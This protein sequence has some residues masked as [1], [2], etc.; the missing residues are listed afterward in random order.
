MSNILSGAYDM[1]VHT[2]PDVSPRK[3]TDL[4]MAI[5]WESAGMKGGV[6]KC[7]FSD[8]TGRAEILSALYPK[9]KI[10]G[11]LVLNRQAGG[12]NPD[13]AERMAQAGG[14]YLWFPTMDSK[15]YQMH[16]VKNNSQK[17]L[18]QYISILDENGKLLPKVYDVI[19]VAAKYDLIVVT[20][21]IGGKEGLPLVLEAARRGVKRIVLTHAENPA[22]FFSTD[23]QKRCVAAGA[24][25]EHSF[26][27]IYHNRVSWE[28][29]MDQIRIVG[30][31]NT[32]LV[33]DF[34]QINSPGSAEG[35]KMFAEGLIERGFT[36]NDIDK[37]IR[38]NQER[39]FF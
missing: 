35:L 12:I 15:S 1:H 4:E 30:T 20:G 28:S 23:D 37:M 10:Y 18:S 39:L 2:S 36:E 29:V 8:T 25:V 14:K 38:K 27:T 9:L 34:G 13:A 5:E 22:T 32:Y 11:G 3:S 31:E 24:M 21:H 16:H 26:F 17:D 6:I 7:H 33:T 19:D